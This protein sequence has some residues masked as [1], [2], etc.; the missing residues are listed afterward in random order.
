MKTVVINKN[1]AGQRLDKFLFKYL[2]GMPASLLYR[3]IRTK[4]IKVNKKKCDIS[5]KLSEGDVLELYIGDEFFEKSSKAGNLDRINAD[6]NIVY[7]DGNIILVNKPAGVIVHESE[8]DKNTT[9]IE[10][11]CAYLYKKGEYDPDAEQSFAPALCNRLDRNTSGIVICAKNAETLRIMNEKIKNREIEKY[12]ICAAAGRFKK[13][14]DTLKAYLMKDERTNTVSVYDSPRPGAKT[15][16][17]QY[18]V[19]KEKGDISLLRVHL[20]TGRTH[21]IRAHLSH[22]GHPLIGDGKYGIGDL[23]R[24]LGQ[25]H[26]LLCTYKL[27]FAFTGEKTALEYLNGREFELTDVPFLKLF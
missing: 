20:I 5:Y 4:R 9:L 21:Q 17:T 11:V 27:R 13:K 23:N 14:E 26:Q 22:I 7:E 6:I 10:A 16:I 12:Y 24:G 8:A 18:R 3:Y 25:K 2:S 19:L 15:I 1:D